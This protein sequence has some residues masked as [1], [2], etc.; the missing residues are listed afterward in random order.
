MNDW[1]K[2]HSGARPPSL[3]IGDQVVCCLRDGGVVG[4]AVGPDSTEL[5]MTKAATPM[6]CCG[7][8]SVRL[9]FEAKWE[10]LNDQI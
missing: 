5:C 10:M 7:G 3:L 9:V 2:H 4:V 1:H 6:R 8:W